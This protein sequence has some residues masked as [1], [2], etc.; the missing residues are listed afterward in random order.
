MGMLGLDNVEYPQVFG[1]G[2]DVRNG[3]AAK[4]DIK[5]RE[6]ILAVPFNLLITTKNIGKDLKELMNEYPSLFSAEETSD[7]EHLQLTLYLMNEIQK[8]MKSA[9]FPYL[10]IIPEDVNIFYNW[11]PDVL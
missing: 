2:K 10:Q 8:G 5:H 9:L 7:S 1:S 3:V 6:S 4:R 11:G